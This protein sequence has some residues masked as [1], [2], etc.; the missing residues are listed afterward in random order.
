MSKVDAILTIAREHRKDSITEPGFRNIL[1]AADALALSPDETCL[2]LEQMDFTK[3]SDPRTCYA[4]KFQSILD[5][6][7]AKKGAA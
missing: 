7:L 1:R 2:L 3:R 5:K 6:W 4:S